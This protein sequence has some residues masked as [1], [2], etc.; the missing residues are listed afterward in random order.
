MVTMSATVFNREPSAV[1]RK[2]MESSEPVVVT[3]RDQPSLV[4][5]RYDDYIRLTGNA[6]VSDLAEWLQL[7]TDID[8]DIPSLGFGLKPVDL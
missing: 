7:D 4:V 2:V 5:M 6:T 8:I 1:K 3:E